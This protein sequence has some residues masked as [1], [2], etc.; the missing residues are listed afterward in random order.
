MWDIKQT[1]IFHIVSVIESEP[2]NKH[3]LGIIAIG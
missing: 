2:G 3:R 1:L